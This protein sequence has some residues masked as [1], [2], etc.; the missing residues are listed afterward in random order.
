MTDWTPRPSFTRRFW[1]GCAVVLFSFSFLVAALI[2][3]TRADAMTDG[4]PW[5]QVLFGGVLCLVGVRLALSGGNLAA[6]KARFS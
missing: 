6:L 1:V 3:F 4:T 5:G 2:G